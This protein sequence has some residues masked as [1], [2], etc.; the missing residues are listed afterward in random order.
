[1]C[2][3]NS[4]IVSQSSD[5]YLI[6]KEL[7]RLYGYTWTDEKPIRMPCNGVLILMCNVFATFLYLV[8]I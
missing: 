2:K 8:C 1:M 6:E 7:Y 4:T 3:T 5:N